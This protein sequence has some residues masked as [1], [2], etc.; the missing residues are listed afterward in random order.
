[1]KHCLYQAWFGKV[2][3]EGARSP[4]WKSVK[5]KSRSISREHPREK[6]YGKE[7]PK[8]KVISILPQRKGER[9]H[10]KRA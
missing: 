4:G 1:L 10:R 2:P 5:V 9:M 3:V 8:K 6:T 7:G